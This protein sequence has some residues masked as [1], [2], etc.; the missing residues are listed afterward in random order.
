MSVF[1]SAVSPF[2]RPW[3]NLHV[4][5]LASWTEPTGPVPASGSLS[6][7]SHPGCFWHCGG[8]TVVNLPLFLWCSLNI[9]SYIFWLVVEPTHLKNMLVKMGI[10]PKIGVNIKHIWN[11]HP[12]LAETAW[13]VSIWNLTPPENE[14][15]SPEKGT[16]SKWN[17]IF[18]PSICREHV[19]ADMAVFRR[20]LQSITKNF[21][22]IWRDIKM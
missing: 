16:M 9:F 21:K 14:R 18:Q 17:Y 4:R 12:V 3:I 15:M 2:K 10:F 13:T 19:S 7:W 22:K 8:F 5:P 6:S 1:F 20:A 11:H